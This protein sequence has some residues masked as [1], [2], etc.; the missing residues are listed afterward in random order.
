MRRVRQAETHDEAV[1]R[2]LVN[3]EN[4]RRVR[5]AETHDEA[6]A[7]KLVNAENMRRVRQAETHDEA[8]ARKLVNA[9]NM[10]R[11]RQVE[12]PIEA[13]KRRRCDV[14]SKRASREAESPQQA[15]ERR[16]KDREGKRARNMQS[17]RRQQHPDEDFFIGGEVPF[18]EVSQKGTKRAQELLLRTA[19][20][21]A[22]GGDSEHQYHRALGCVVC[23]EHI[24]GVEDVHYVTKNHL[25]EHKER[26]GVESYEGFH[27]VMD[28]ELKRQY[29]VGGLEGI[30][31][32][33][34]FGRDNADA[35]TV[36]SCCY[37]SLRK[38][39]T[40]SP[41]KY[42]IANGF[43]I[44]SIPET[45]VYRNKDGDEE[46]VRTVTEVRDGEGNVIP[47]HTE[48]N[49]TSIMAAALSPVRPFAYIFA[50]HG[51]MHTSL[52]G[53]FQFFE[54]SQG[55]L[56]GALRCLEESGMTSNIYV[57]MNGRMTPTQKDIVRRKAELDSG[58]YFALLH[59]L[60][61][62]HPGFCD[63]DID[64]ISELKIE[65]IEDNQVDDD[66]AS[67][68]EENKEEGAVFYFSSGGDPTR[69]TS[70]YKSSKELVLAL[71]KDHSAPTITIH[72][73]NYASHSDVMHLENVFP[74]VFPFGSGGPTT[75]RRNKIS[76][77]DKIRHYLRLSLPQFMESEFILVA[78][79]LL[80]RL[81]SYNTAVAKCRPIIDED[82]TA[83]GDV[84]GNMTIDDIKDAIESEPGQGAQGDGRGN[85][86]GT[87]DK[88]L[89]AVSASCRCL[90]MTEEAAKK[91]RRKCF[92]LQEFY[93]M[94][95]LFVTITIDDECS[96]RIRLYPSV[97][98]NGGAVSASSCMTCNITITTSPC[99]CAS[100]LH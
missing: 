37:N 100:D 22:D 95:S 85:G 26:L 34:R 35:F 72:G 93:G 11:V 51:G 76:D 31:L 21:M 8:V 77:E 69:E 15:D 79:F 50:Y 75:E 83:I 60:K 44:G 59:W 20:D 30:L 46:R 29:E 32:S 74:T 65:L 38:G 80:G 71:L 27:G 1:A 39:T 28:E 99:F 91:A 87:A 25:L 33:R 24:I 90:G 88:L 45:I 16:L 19:V 78:N 6:V 55:K 43:A 41:P 17:P 94:H 66:S 36:C 81:L 13:A 52:R 84:I 14:E 63:V 98:A 86:N 10:R 54:T 57:V 9:E 70:V 67:P 62:H 92:A 73:G 58:L 96:F 18:I 2:K 47:A 53:N 42:S 23:D 82:G 89:K 56:S 48:S 64:E 97:D 61:E 4:M 7:R 12:T 40:T 68:E 5:Q 3:A 49:V